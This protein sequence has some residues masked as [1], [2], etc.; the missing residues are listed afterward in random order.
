MK[1]RNEFEKKVL[2]LTHA[3]TSQSYFIQS[4]QAQVEKLDSYKTVMKKQE[5]VIGRLEALLLEKMGEKKGA[6]GIAAREGLDAGDTAELGIFRVL[7]DENKSLK[8]K[9]SDLEKKVSCFN[10]L[11]GV[12]LC[13]QLQE[14]ESSRAEERVKQLEQELDSAKKRYLFSFHFHITII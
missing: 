4:L 14:K 11:K 9:V 2:E 13:F 6:A 8:Q 3:H 1:Q 5:K 12:Y 7:S 10:I